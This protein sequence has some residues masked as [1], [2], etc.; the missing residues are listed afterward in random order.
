MA[1]DSS[2]K[3]TEPPRLVQRVYA[4]SLVGQ[5]LRQTEIL[6]NVIEIRQ[7]LDSFQRQAEP[8][9]NERITH[10]FALIITQDC[11]LEQDFFARS[12]A[13][14]TEVPPER[15]LPNVLLCA[16][17]TVQELMARTP[18][19]H[20]IWKRVLENRDER[21]HFLQSVEPSEDA[22]GKGLL[23]MGID[24]KRYFTVPTDELYAQLQLGANRRCR[25]AGPYLEHLSGRFA[26]FLSRVALPRPH[27]TG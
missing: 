2:E 16:V 1:S 15:L 27:E 20:D 10:P 5:P 4:P 24:F 22:L 23:P 9:E 19:G 26:Y 6:S 13:S 14:P 3:P 11:D 21:Y 7:T 12:A 8:A 18:K 25:L 17:A